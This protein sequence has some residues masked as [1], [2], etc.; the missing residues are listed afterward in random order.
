[1]ATPIPANRCGFSVAEIISAT[2][3]SFTG[4]GGL[5]VEGVSIDTRSIRPGELFVALRGERDGH[6]YLHVAAANAAA[7]IVERGR[8][9]PALPCFEVDDTLT[10]LGA[11]AKHHRQ[12]IRAARQLATIAV[13]GAAGKTTTKELTAALMRAIFGETLSTP[14]NLNNRI[15]VPMT[16]LLLTEK[17][18]AAVLEC[19]TNQRGEIAR[20]GEIIAPDAALVLNVDIE[21][22]E[23]LGSLGSIADE[24]AALFSA[25][26]IA[27][28]GIAEHMLTARVPAPIP[29]ISFGTEPGADVRLVA[30]RVLS[31][32]QQRV[33]LALPPSMVEPGVLPHLE[34]TLNLLG[35]AAA[36]NAAAAVAATAAVWGKAFGTHQIAAMSE[37][38]ASVGPVAGRLAPTDRGG[39]IVIDDSYNANPRSVRA[40]LAAAREVADALQ[41]RLVVALGDM[42]EL[43]DLSTEMHRTILREVVAAR[44]DQ[45]FAIGPE[46]R[47][48]LEQLT[49]E[50]DDMART[51]SAIDS[52]EAA[53]LVR[54]FVRPGDVLLVK[55]SRGIKMERIVHELSTPDG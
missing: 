25:A 40:A 17:Y 19:G 14:G 32:G 23:G 30:R 8:G 41:T 26:R 31:P 4:A 52:A 3:A 37:A 50:S 34:A 21:H 2:G 39:I 15:G 10:A 5:R 20:L 1:M 38:L 18:D 29:R 9:H 6:D 43:G 35:A 27:V 36:G 51:R 47:T 54:S 12:R 45:F 13:G 33:K 24:E 53:A 46:I 7:A 16:L 11:L 55:G 49:R 48:A 44:P 28:V 22:S 42:L